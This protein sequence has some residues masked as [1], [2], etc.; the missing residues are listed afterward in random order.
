VLLAARGDLVPALE[1]DEIQVRLARDL[2]PQSAHVSLAHS[3]FLRAIA[4]DR[5]A[6]M[7]RLDELL[8]LWRASPQSVT[9][10]PS[11]LA[12]AAALLGRQE[13]F[14]AVANTARE[15]R[16]L[17]AACAFARGNPA[18][19]ADLFAEI[20]SRPHEAYARLAAGD[21]ANVR[22]A[23]DFYRSVGAKLFMAR[24]ESLLPASA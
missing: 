5:E 11:E 15:T 2:D 3:C 17:A 4:G 9:F 6:A 22:R 18:E 12:F 20:G 1:E 16:W 21:E 24:A 13:D 14:L 19:A 23:L 10:N 7:E 8:R